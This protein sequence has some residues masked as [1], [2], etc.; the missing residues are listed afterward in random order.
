ME[1][2]EGGPVGEYGV[3][4]DLLDVG[5][6]GDGVGRHLEVAHVLDGAVVLVH[7]VHLGLDL[8]EGVA[9]VPDLSK[10]GECSVSQFDNFRKL[11]KR[12][13]VKNFSLKYRCW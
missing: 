13:R 2:Q 11:R 7:Q 9:G 12:N 8:V 5:Q 10:M 6:V 4:V 3:D 1:V